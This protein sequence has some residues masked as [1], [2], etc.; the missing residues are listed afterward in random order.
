MAQKT[1]IGNSIRIARE[2]RGLTQEEL[3][4]IIG[5]TLDTICHYENGTW[6]APT[7]RVPALAKALGVSE[8]VLLKNTDANTFTLTKAEIR[9]L[10]NYRKLDE[11]GVKI[12]SALTSYLASEE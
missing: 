8:N 3:A 12:I 10:D 4:K 7:K 11:K 1:T 9:L 6:Q 5:V 2:C